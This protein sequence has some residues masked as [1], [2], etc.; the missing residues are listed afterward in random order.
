MDDELRIDNIYRVVTRKKPLR[1]KRKKGD[2]DQKQ[3][4]EAGSNFQHLV[5]AAE[6]A[7]TLLEKNHS[8]YRFCVYQK[9]EEVFIDIVIVGEGGEIREIRKKN[10]THDEFSTWINHIEQ[11]EGFF[12]DVTA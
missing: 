4:D 9:D 8:P 7:H 11:G 1:S 3:R 6:A 2:R 12:L 10:I 5:E